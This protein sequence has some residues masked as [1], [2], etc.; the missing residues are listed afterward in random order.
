MNFK[1]NNRQHSCLYIMK[2]PYHNLS[3]V[4]SENLFI[5]ALVFCD[6]CVSIHGTT[7]LIVTE[8]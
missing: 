5:I 2:V 6:F 8:V 4:Q 3:F 7:L 1:D